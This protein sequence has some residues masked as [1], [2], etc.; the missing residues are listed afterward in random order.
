M[1][2][3]IIA[4][5]A[6]NLFKTEGA[7]FACVPLTIHCGDREFT[8]TPDLDLDE[9]LDFLKTTKERSS[10]SCPNVQDWLDAFGEAE[11]VYGVT[12]TSNLSGSYSAAMQAKELYLQEHPERKVHIFDTL[13]AGPE[14]ELA[15]EKLAALLKEGCS[16]EETVAALQDY[17]KKTH[18]LFSLESVQNLARNGRVSAAKA[19]LVGVLGIRIVGK[20]SDQGTLQPLHNC[21]GA[22]KNLDTI[23]AV[24]KEHG[25]RGGKVRIAHCRNEAAAEALKERLKKWIP[26]C[27][28]L[29]RRCTALCSFYAEIGGLMI[30]FEG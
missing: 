28:I 29:V 5:S 30:G 21:R 27:E 18:L 7:A 4:D 22:K 12:I 17:L 26:V 24:M 2:Y 20:A 9:M 13:S 23:L 1:A 3:K 16:F 25:F 10:T 11:E 8:D 6:S 14:M 19:K 15:V